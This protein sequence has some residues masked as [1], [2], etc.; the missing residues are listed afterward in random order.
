MKSQREV[1]HEWAV[2]M[3]RYGF[4]HQDK[5]SMRRLAA[6]AGVTVNAVLRVVY[7]EN[8]GEDTALKVGQALR[9]PEFVAGWVSVELGAE[10]RPPASAR[11]LSPRQRLL[12]DDLIRELTGGTSDSRMPEAPKTPPTGEGAAPTMADHKPRPT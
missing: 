7:R 9:D 11:K 4:T 12:V 2:R 5:P 6:A 1:P 10:Y 8:F 3:R